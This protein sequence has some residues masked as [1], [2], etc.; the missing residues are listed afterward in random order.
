MVTIEI[1]NN[2]RKKES[3][4]INF[5]KFKLPH[6]NELFKNLRL[7]IKSQIA[8]A[9]DLY[10][11]NIELSMRSD[12]NVFWNHIKNKKGRSRIPGI[13]TDGNTSFR[14]PQSIVNAFSEYFS[15]V[16]VN[17]DPHQTCNQLLIQDALIHIADIHDNEILSAIKKLKNKMTS[18]VDGIPSFLIK[19]CANI[20]I[21][22]LRL[23]F[24]LA[25]KSSTFPSCWKTA[26]VCP[27]LKSG[28]ISNIK[29][30]RPIAILSN[31]SKVFEIIL[32][33]YVY[34]SVNHL[35]SPSQHGFMKHKSTTSNLTCIV[36]YIANTL[37]NRG[38]VD[39]IYTDIQKAFDQ[40]DLYTLLKK[41][42]CIG[43]SQPLLCLFESYLFGRMHF[44]SFNNYY[45][46]TYIAKSGVP[47]G[48]NLGPLLFLIFVNDLTERLT[49][50]KL[51]F[52]DDLK[53]YATINDISDCETLQSQL[54]LVYNWC[55]SNS[56]T[57]NISKC[58]T[59]SYSR[60]K[61]V[62]SYQYN[63]NNECI[64]RSNCVK[65]LGIM[66]DEKL[67]F[68]VHVDRTVSSALKSLGFIIRNTHNFRNIQCLKILYFSL[69]RS[70]L[71]YGAVIWNPFYKYE[72]KL[73]EKVQIKFLKYMYYK[74]Q[75][76]YPPKDVDIEILMCTFNLDSLKT[77][78][79]RLLVS[80]LYKLL[81]NQIDCPS[82]L[83]Q[84]NFLVPRANSRF[85]LT[86]YPNR[87]NTNVIIKSPL[88]KMC[89][90]FNKKSKQFDIN[91]HTLSS[92]LKCIK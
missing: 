62:I 34:A 40:I 38:Q 18:G 44:V 45:S 16:H 7:L 61:E 41:L 36:Q 37:D 57:L 3:A 75:H 76:V 22:P 4:R 52:A 65:D 39:V 87:A 23:I 89:D 71:E 26:R 68:N 21:R 43:F 92:I 54:N 56:L 5:K 31:F 72:I 25:L 55:T 2:L 69:V 29:N 42:K 14:D 73:C 51:M 46:N 35:I 60:K 67:S 81:H 80:F 12:I 15:S 85:S 27:V 47:Q 59:V 90:V 8:E 17:S 88:N 19:D 86:F 6:Y 84:I 70:K 64:S 9:Y 13:M 83:E 79:E 48:S 28:D 58:T 10:I 33:N 91:H 30:Y 11:T 20:F 77:R 82:L 78:R 53:I 74:S 24:T 49:C 1:I 32:F 63:I 50:N 66:F